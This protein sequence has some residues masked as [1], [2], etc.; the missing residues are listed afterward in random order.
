MGVQLARILN[1]K[2]LRRQPPKGS[3]SSHCRFTASPS[4]KTQF[5]ISDIP[6]MYDLPYFTEHLISLER[7]CNFD[8]LFYGSVT[9]GDR[10]QIVIPAEARAELGIS[11]GDKLL[12]MR[13]PKVDGLMVCKLESFMAM[14]EGLRVKLGQIEPSRD[15]DTAEEK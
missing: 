10:G 14:I 12:V 6:E 8:D 5:Q 4:K 9:V 13:D 1:Y 11:A 3:G 15:A 2:V 7:P